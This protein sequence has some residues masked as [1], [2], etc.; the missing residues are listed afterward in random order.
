MFVPAHPLSGQFYI[1][2]KDACLFPLDIA[3]TMTQRQRSRI[4]AFE[5]SAF[6]REYGRYRSVVPG[7]V[8]IQRVHRR[9]TGPMDRKLPTQMV[10]E[11]L[12]FSKKLIA[13]I[14]ADKCVL[15]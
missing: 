12:N 11:H 13:K 4:G 3:R 2:G 5:R 14:P 10:T 7:V 8:R 15:I 6:H 9:L 1:A